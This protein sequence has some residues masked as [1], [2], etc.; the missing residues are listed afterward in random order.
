MP[1]SQFLETDT[2]ILRYHEEY[3]QSKHPVAYLIDVRVENADVHH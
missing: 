2:K 1:Y 3:A